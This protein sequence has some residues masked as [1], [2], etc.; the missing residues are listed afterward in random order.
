VT[1]APD[2]SIPIGVAM[3]ESSQV[4]DPGA[5]TGA[6]V[7][8]G[9]VVEPEESVFGM[10]DAQPRLAKLVV[11]VVAVI[12]LVVLFALWHDAWWHWFEVHTGTVNESGPYYGFWSGFGSDLGE[13]TLVVGRV[14]TWH[15]H[16]CHIKRCPW[17][18]RQVAGTPYVACP[19]HHPEHK[20][21]K[22]AISLEELHRAHKAAKAD[23]K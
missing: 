1:Y 19:K 22:R 3:D 12:A 20:G 14:A 23:K 7:D 5:Q 8:A 9:A 13:A 21:S 18:G 11:L 10:Y 15:H 6:R 2:E 17:L 16:N 4:P